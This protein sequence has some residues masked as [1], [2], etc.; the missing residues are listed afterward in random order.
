MKRRHREK[1]LE[2]VWLFRILFSKRRAFRNLGVFDPYRG[3]I[4]TPKTPF[5]GLLGSQGGSK[6]GPKRAKNVSEPLKS[7]PDLRGS[8][9]FLRGAQKKAPILGP[10]GPAPIDHCLAATSD[11]CPP[12]VRRVNF[13]IPKK[14]VSGPLIDALKKSGKKRGSSPQKNALFL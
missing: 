2:L 3:P 8:Q 13:Q 14:R 4:G 10:P 11:K 7:D 12:K 1:H 6:M 5:L 9:T